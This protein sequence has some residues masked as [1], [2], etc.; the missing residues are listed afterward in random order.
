VE[1]PSSQASRQRKQVEAVVFHSSYAGTFASFPLTRNVS[2]VRGSDRGK[3]AKQ[4]LKCEKSLI[5][6]AMGRNEMDQHR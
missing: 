6:L 3:M 4:L 5:Q 2:V 1:Q